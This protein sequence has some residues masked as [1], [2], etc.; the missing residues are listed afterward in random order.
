[1]LLKEIDVFREGCAAFIDGSP[2]KQNPYRPWNA[3]WV[4][5]LAGWDQSAEANSNELRESRLVA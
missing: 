3:A 5:W 4:A 2:R 1:V